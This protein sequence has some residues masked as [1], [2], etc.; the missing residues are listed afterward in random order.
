M[1]EMNFGGANSGQDQE[2]AAILSEL[3]DD[4]TALKADVIALRGDAVDLGVA[5]A[6]T[7]SETI[8]GKAESVIDAAKDQ[9][10]ELTGDAQKLR[11]QLKDATRRNPYG[12]LGVSLAVGILIGRGFLKN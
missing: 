4:M 10:A 12:A 6:K 2:L 5:S 11:N 8:Q 1:S 3:R 9:A 7:A